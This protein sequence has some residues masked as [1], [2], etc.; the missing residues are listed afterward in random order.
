MDWN[1][2]ESFCLLHLR[3]IVMAYDAHAV[4]MLRDAQ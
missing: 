1:E 2:L 3:V 4:S